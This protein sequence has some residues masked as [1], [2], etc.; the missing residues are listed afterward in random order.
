MTK[1][2][3]I[4]ADAGEK[5]PKVKAGRVFGGNLYIR[6]EPEGNIIGQ[7]ADGAQVTILSTENGWHRIAA[8]MTG[9]SEDGQPEYKEAYVMAKWVK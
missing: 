2:K 8:E 4:K 3:E 6:S 7:L 1:E 9:I 5:N